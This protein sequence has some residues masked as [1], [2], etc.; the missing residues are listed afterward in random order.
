ML[1]PFSSPRRRSSTGAARQRTRLM[2][3]ELEARLVLTTFSEPVYDLL[4]DRTDFNQENFFVYRDADSPYNHGFPSGFFGTTSQLRINTAALDDPGSASGVSTDPNRLDR[5]RGNV[6]QVTFDPLAP[7]QFAGFNFEEPENFGVARNG[8]GYDL[9]GATD[10]EFE[11][12]S[13][14]PGGINVQFGVGQRTAPFVHIPQSSTFI[15]MRISL[16][17]LAL[18]PQELANVHILFTVV[19]NDV[20]APGGGI[21]LL[22]NVR[23][24][25][26]PVA[27]R[28]ALGFPLANETFGVVPLGTDSGSRV[29]F[30]QDQVFRNTSTIYESA[31]ALRALLDRGTPDELRLARV[32]ADTFVYAL[33]HDNAGLMLPEVN[34]SGGLHSGYSAGDIALRNAIGGGQAGDARLSGFTCT[35]PGSGGFCLV[36]DGTTGGNNALAMLGLIQAFERFDDVNYLEAAREIGRWTA[37]TLEDTT[38][39]GLGGYYFGFL[40][41]ARIN[42]GVQ[43][44]KS[45]ENNADIFAAF[46]RLSQVERSLGNASQANFWADK[47][48]VAGD[49]VMRLFDEERGRFYLGTI[50]VGTNPGPLTPGPTVGSDVILV[51]DFLDSNSFAVLALAPSPRYRDAI[52]WR[53]PVQYIVDN[54]PVTV[55][56]AGQTFQGFSIVPTPSAGP[57]GIAWEFTGQA[58]VAMR[59]V[60]ALYGE[61]RFGPTADFFLG[62]LARAQR[63]AP[64]TD[65]RGLP[66]STVQDGDRLPPLEQALSTPFQPI[67][68]RVG[69]AASLWALFADRPINF[70]Q[71]SPRR[72][73]IAAVDPTGG[74]D[75]DEL[76]WYLRDDTSSGG[77]TIFPFPF[78]LRSWVPQLGDWNASGMDTIGV[79]DPTAPAGL[80]WYLRNSRSAGAPDIGPF[81]YG[82]SGWMPV[83]GDWNGDMLD[84]VGVVDPTGGQDPINLVWYLRNQNSSGAA[85]FAPFAFGLRGWVP[86]AGDWNGDGITTPGVYDPSTATWYLRTSNEVLNPQVISFAYGLPGWV[87]VVG[88]WD[89][90]GTDSIGVLDPGGNWFLRNHNNPG[91]PDYGP[92][93]YGLGNWVP[94]GATQTLT[95]ATLRA[96]G[97][98]HQAPSGMSL[99]E[100]DLQAAVAAALARLEQDG[101]PAALVDQLARSSYGIGRLPGDLLG[102]ADQSSGRVLLDEDAAGLGWFVDP[103]PSSDEEFGPAGSGGEAEGRMDLLT[104][105]LHEMGHLAGL[106]DQDSPGTDL[107]APTLSAGERHIAILDTLFRSGL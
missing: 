90:D 86:V 22:D 48:T 52:D 50:P 62:E 9:T 85:D 99:A 91:A 18:T 19:T 7:S 67:A 97:G 64:F 35:I 40:D 104:V 69:L 81:A 12:R 102:L 10:I 37:G 82:G 45:I 101:V 47:A 56:A 53:Q 15:P 51:D 4:G 84:S 58:V 96:S 88:D 71:P 78:G 30:P 6:L 32:I 54:F 41:G 59:V 14:T 79:A 74:R 103:T 49:F 61:N 63:L 46:S 31:L 80:T 76:V 34:G 39:T 26:V 106:P 33:N 87:P 66:A 25:P 89:G 28:A 42:Q 92:F 2:V 60:D 5:V 27:Q 17:S 29:P 20:N 57:E 21:V 16:A 83:V 107:M 70:F 68:E 100:A 36:L 8:Q 23:F 38:G 1:L 73:T 98:S 65:G 105:V 95:L 24:T 75:P 44:N 3:E 93:P 94:L 43:K 72:Q 55:T 11:V 13:P 77:P